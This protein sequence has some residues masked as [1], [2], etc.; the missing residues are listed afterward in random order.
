MCVLPPGKLGWDAIKDS[1]GVRLWDIFPT[2]QISDIAGNGADLTVLIDGAYG[3]SIE[4]SKYR[5]FPVKAQMTGDS[6]AL[7]VSLALLTPSRA[8]QKVEFFMRMTMWRFIGEIAAQSAFVW[9][10]LGIYIAIDSR[11]F[12]SLAAVYV[13][14]FVLAGIAMS[15]LPHAM[16]SKYRGKFWSTQAVLYGM[17]GVPEIAWLERQLLGFSEGR[18][19]WSPHGSTLS[20]HKVKEGRGE[21]LDGECEALAPLLG[22]ENAPNTPGSGWGRSTLSDDGMRVFTLVDTSAMTVTAFRAKHPPTVA[23]VLYVHNVPP[24]FTNIK[25]ANRKLTSQGSRRRDALC[26]Y[27]HW[28]Q[29]FHQETIV[30]MPTKVLDRMDRVDKS[31]FSLK[32]LSDHVGNKEAKE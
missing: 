26:S 6:C 20:Q 17:E 2:C 9:L 19:T 14:F 18:L 5:N 1:W 8:S 32:S 16:F 11:G 30:R 31:R 21:M 15:V 25:L 28:T 3:A 4:W 24:A 10:L 12:L 13:I 22:S 7:C 27:N 29:T 23:H